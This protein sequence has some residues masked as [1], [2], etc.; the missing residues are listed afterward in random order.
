MK[1]LISSRCIEN[2]KFKLFKHLEALPGNKVAEYSRE[3]KQEGH[4]SEFIE[5]IYKYAN[6]DDV[7]AIQS[8][9]NES[10]GYLDF[11]KLKA[12]IIDGA[13]NDEDIYMII[14]AK[15][16]CELGDGKIDYWFSNKAKNL[17]FYKHSAARVMYFFQHECKSVEDFKDWI[18]GFFVVERFIQTQKLEWDKFIDYLKSSGCSPYVCEYFEKKG[19]E[20]FTTHRYQ[21]RY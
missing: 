2:K 10:L 13:E 6:S 17:M 7:I 1:I 19:S 16:I 20:Y 4:Q 9:I 12:W 14:H 5:G 8:N 15:D 21:N 3:L 18:Y 11:N